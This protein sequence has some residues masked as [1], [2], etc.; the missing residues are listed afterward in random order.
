M[1]TFSCIATICKQR[2]ISTKK[3]TGFTNNKQPGEGGEEEDEGG[4]GTMIVTDCHKL[5]KG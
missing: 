4:E 3:T 5:E 1:V 2:Y